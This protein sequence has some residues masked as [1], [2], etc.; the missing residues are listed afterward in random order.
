MASTITNLINTIDTTYPVAGVDNDSQGFRN[1]FTIIQQSLLATQGEIDSIN[2]TISTLGGTVYSTATHIHA[3]QD[4]TIGTTG[5]V[6]LS[7]NSS[8]IIASST[9]SSE[10]LLGLSVIIT[11]TAAYALTDSPTQTT[12]TVFAVNSVNNIQVGATVEIGSSNYTVSAI[13][14]STNYI[15][16]STPFTVGSFA[17][18]DTLTF[19]NPYIVPTGT[20]YLDGDI[21]VTGNITAFAGSPS[22]AR[23][24]E[25]VQTINNALSIVNQLRGVTYDWTDEYVNSLKLH[26][27]AK[28]D[29]GVIAQEVQAVFPLVVHAKDNGDL[30]VHYEKLTGL[31]I[32]AV[33]ELSAKVAALEAK[34]NSL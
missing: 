4:V 27:Q 21:S 33:K 30:T 29:T 13:D 11:A 10:R 8:G 24:K 28:Q 34:N 31:L 17:V 2:N 12:A 22:D 26:G 14:P 1:N 20:L 3:L 16:V 23:L 32:E 19:N 18:G 5:S 15:T 25:N 6:V 7:A 9:A